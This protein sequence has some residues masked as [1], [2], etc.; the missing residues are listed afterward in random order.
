[1]D[2]R[3]DGDLLVAA[4]EALERLL[5]D[6]AAG[7]KAVA[8]VEKRRK[9][10][11][12]VE[13]NASAGM[14]PKDKNSPQD[15]WQVVAGDPDN[16]QPR[17]RSSSMHGQKGIKPGENDRKI[18]TAS[19]QNSPQTRHMQKQIDTDNGGFLRVCGDGNL[20]QKMR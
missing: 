15:L 4:I 9:N 1:M 17:E 18:P 6:Q 13:V 8:C 10:E 19:T 7:R 2:S 16:C 11:S 3:A 5:N 20:W 12:Y 14:P